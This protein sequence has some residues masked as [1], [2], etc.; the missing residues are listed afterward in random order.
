MSNITEYLKI[1]RINGNVDRG[2]WQCQ[3][4]ALRDT[5]LLEVNQKIDVSWR[6][7]LGGPPSLPRSAFSGYV[8]P[9]RHQLDRIGSTTE[10]TAETSDGYLRRGWVQ[11]IGFAEID[12][13]THYHQFSDTNAECPAQEMGY[14]MTMGK[15]VKHILGYYDD[16]AD[17]GPEW[18]AHTNLV[19]HP[20]YNPQGW[21]SLD[22]VEISE[23]SPANPDGSMAITRYNVRETDNLWSRLTEIARNE[24]FVI[25]FDKLD[26]LH[27]HKHPMYLAG[28]LPTPVMTFDED[29]GLAPLIVT[30]RD[31]QQVRQVILHAVDD[32]GSVLHSE[33]PASPTYVYGKTEEVSRVRCNSQATLDDWVE[34]LYLWLNRDYTVEWTAPGLCGLLFELY[35]RVQVTYAGTAAN[36]V[37]IDWTEKKFWIHEIDVTPGQAFGGVTRFRLEAE[38]V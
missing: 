37:D 32:E 26:T 13:R 34:R 36:G 8:T 17:I 38:S 15:L 19:Y 25:Y 4:T 5:D 6:P 12:A 10:I 29:F 24:F 28:A 30:P 14:S 7:A 3:G 21:I 1:N 16:C 33:Y 23:W 20:T 11:G 27:Y 9:N 18:V 31:R 22:D 35:D 2:G